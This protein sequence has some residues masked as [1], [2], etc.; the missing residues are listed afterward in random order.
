MAERRKQALAV[1]GSEFV[2]ISR[3][4]ALGAAPEL[5]FAPFCE[6]VSLRPKASAYG[7]SSFVAYSLHRSAP[8]EAAIRGPSPALG[9]GR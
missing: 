2:P 3:P 7:R 1:A 8:R 9:F 5:P 6:I 4:G